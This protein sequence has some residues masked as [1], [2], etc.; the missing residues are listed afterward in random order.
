MSFDS[1]TF[2]G[3]MMRESYFIRVDSD[4]PLELML[5]LNQDGEKSIRYIGMFEPT[6][7]KGTSLIDVKQFMLGE[8]KCIQFSL[9]SLSSSDLFYKLCNDLIDSSRDSSE[10]SG[11]SFI[12]SR[13]ARWKK[14]FVSRTGILTIEMIMGLMGELSFLKDY[15]IPKYGVHEAV[16][17]WS[18]PETTVKD[19]SINDEWFEIKTVGSQS[20]TVNINSLQQLDS[21][22]KGSLVVYYLER[23]SPTFKGITLN[24]LVEDLMKEIPS[25]D[26]SDLFATKI[27]SLGYTYN[28]Q[29]D[30]IVFEIKNRRQFIVDN[31]FPVIR[32]DMIPAAVHN[33]KYELMISSLQEFEVK[34]E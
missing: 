25:V 24:S 28:D 17:S 34:G 4:H 27:T 2:F 30:E 33:V 13:F 9:K 7:V 3:G 5:G 6:K 19:F 16:Q 10:A 31:N 11:Y 12:T 14:M 8:K 20:L 1:K 22:L 23:M 26:D 18:A 21:Q 32:K 29:Y 15:L